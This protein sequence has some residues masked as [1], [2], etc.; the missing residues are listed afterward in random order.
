MIHCEGIWWWFGV[1]DGDAASLHGVRAYSSADLVNWRDHGIVL[2]AD[3]LPGCELDS[4]RAL[5]CPRTGG[6]VLWFHLV[7]P[8]TAGVAFAP[9]PGEPFVFLHGIRSDAAMTADMTILADSNGSV[10]H[11]FRQEGD[12]TLFAAPLDESLTRHEEGAVRMA[13]GGLCRTPVVMK[14]DGI[15]WLLAADKAG[16]VLLATGESLL[17]RWVIDGNPCVGSEV[18][19]LSFFNSRP[20]CLVQ[21]SE[22]VVILVADDGVGHHVW[23]PFDFS[24][25]VP[26]L[27]WQWDWAPLKKVGKDVSSRKPRLI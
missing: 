27:H 6:I 15:Y 7:L 16:E 17:S 23:L 24:H 5:V 25:R 19:M 4:P 2:A 10:W 9:A 11:I 8:G 14:W 26:E 1:D 21:V 20:S 3:H 18:Q 12:E 22:D 13:T